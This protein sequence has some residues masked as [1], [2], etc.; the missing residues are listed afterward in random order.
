[1]VLALHVFACIL[2]RLKYE[3]D[4]DGLETFLVGKDLTMDVS[5]LPL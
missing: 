1:M 5:A 2:W 3:N 4:P